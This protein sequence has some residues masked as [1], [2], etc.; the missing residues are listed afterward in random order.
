LSP[1]TNIH[2]LSGMQAQ[3]DHCAASILHF[4]L[5][6]LVH[7]EDI[8]VIALGVRTHPSLRSDVLDKA[9]SFVVFFFNSVVDVSAD[10]C[11]KFCSLFVVCNLALMLHLSIFFSRKTSKTGYSVAFSFHCCFVGKGQ[12]PT[13]MERQV[14]AS[15]II[16]RRS[17]SCRCR[18]N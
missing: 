16:V 6:Q 13:F 3:A 11:L 8:R 2:H 10:L 9:S 12:K 15:A 5:R 18:Q 1:S 7:G 4:L 17:V 14:V